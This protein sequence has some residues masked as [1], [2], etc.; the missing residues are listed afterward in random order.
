MRVAHCH[1]TSPQMPGY[2]CPAVSF[3]VELFN[4][5]LNGIEWVGIGQARML[6]KGTYRVTIAVVK[7]LRGSTVSANHARQTRVPYGIRRDYA[8]RVSGHRDFL[9][10]KHRAPTIAGPSLRLN[11]DLFIWQSSGIEQRNCP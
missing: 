9:G 4:G 7:N 5:L 10:S 8:S 6:R 2:C 3:F 11:K 1:G